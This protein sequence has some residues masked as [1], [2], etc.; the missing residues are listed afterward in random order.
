M[1][2]REAVELFL[3]NREW[4]GLS[5]RTR[6]QYRQQLYR[7]VNQFQDLPVKPEDIE[8]F[9]AHI[10]ATPETVHSYIRTLRTF[11]NFLKERRKVPNPMIY[12]ENPKL[13]N[14]VMPTLE[15]EDIQLLSVFVKNQRDKALIHLLLDTGI[16]AGEAINLKRDDINEDFIKVKGK[17]GERIVPISNSVVELLLSLPTHPD[18]YVFHGK[19]GRMTRSGVYYIVRKYLKMIG[20]TG[21]KLGPHRLRHTFGRQFLNLGGDLRS[22]QLQLGH[23]NIQTTQKYANLAINDVIKKHHKYTPLQVME[24]SHA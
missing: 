14:K 12:I 21:D 8:K 22:L 1:K 5:I 2:T 24:L 19:K 7:F 17:V 11:Y 20:I 15:I 23:Q 16:R 10:N 13:S 9:L 18:G 6:Q 4:R 3:S